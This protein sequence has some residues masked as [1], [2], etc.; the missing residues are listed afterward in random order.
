MTML[1]TQ[2]ISSAA[3]AFVVGFLKS[4][5]SSNLK[6]VG[7]SDPIAKGAAAAIQVTSCTLQTPRPCHHLQLP[8]SDFC[9]LF[10]S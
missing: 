3:V 7:W 1:L 10:Q 6:I 9:G 5:N 2:L 8:M 4:Y